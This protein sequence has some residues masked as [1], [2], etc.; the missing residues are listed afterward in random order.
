MAG[1]GQQQDPAAI[2][3]SSDDDVGNDGCGPAGDAGKQ[4]SDSAAGEDAEDMLV[5]MADDR[6]VKAEDDPGQ[7]G[8]AAGSL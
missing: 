8:H 3:I 6:Q 1:A 5:D 2:L 7:V 4:Q